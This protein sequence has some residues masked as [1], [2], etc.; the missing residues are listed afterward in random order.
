M[1]KKKVKISR[2]VGEY[3]EEKRMGWSVASGSKHAER[4]G[5]GLSLY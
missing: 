5:W 4:V 3:L 1:G 2:S